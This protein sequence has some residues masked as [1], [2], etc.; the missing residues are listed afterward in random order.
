VFAACRSCW[1][2]FIRSCDNLSSWRSEPRAGGGTQNLHRDGADRQLTEAVSALAFLDAFG[3]R[4]GATQF[5]PGS[6]RGEA[7]DAPVYPLAKGAEG[8]AGDILLFDVNL[9]HGAT[10]NRSGAPRRSLL[11]TFARAA[12]DPCVAGR[13]HGSGRSV[14]RLSEGARARRAQ[15][16]VIIGKE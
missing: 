8:E 2:P 4:N 6:H 3:S 9:V 5:V 7:Q 14:R 12:K 13:A 16:S 10:R 1:R 11:I 15:S